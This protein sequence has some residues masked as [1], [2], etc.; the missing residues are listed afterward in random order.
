MTPPLATVG[1][2]VLLIKTGNKAVTLDVP[3]VSIPNQLGTDFSWG[4]LEPRGSAPFPQQATHTLGEKSNGQGQG[5][6]QGQIPSTDA[7]RQKDKTGT[8]TQV[9][10]SPSK[11]AGR[12]W[13]PN[14]L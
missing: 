14:R 9:Q 13:Y 6:N 12:Y 3:Q 4:L 8:G 7:D 1:M 10:G 2:T 11:Y 5:G